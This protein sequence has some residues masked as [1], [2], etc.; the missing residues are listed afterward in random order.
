MAIPVD[1]LQWQLHGRHPYYL[2]LKIEGINGQGKVASSNEYEHLIGAPSGGIVVEIPIDT[3]ELVSCTKI[4]Q[5]MQ[6]TS[7]GD[8]HFCMAYNDE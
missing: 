7:N 8:N 2:N 3:S 1:D 5:S 4:L 6:F